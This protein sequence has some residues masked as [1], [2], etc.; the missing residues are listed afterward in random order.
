V[1][2]KLLDESSDPLEDYIAGKVIRAQDD[3]HR[4]ESLRKRSWDAIESEV[5][6]GSADKDM[7][8]YKL[9]WE[10]I[11]KRIWALGSRQVRPNMLILPDLSTK[12]MGSSVLIKSSP[13]ISERLG[14]CVEQFQVATSF[15]PLCDEPMWGLAFVVEASVTSFVT[16]HQHTDTKKCHKKNGRKENKELVIVL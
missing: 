6:Y 10:D 12:E 3:E 1:L 14:F 16:I 11:L 8:N 5:T 4:V 15:G 7:E 9:L 2:T 13:Y